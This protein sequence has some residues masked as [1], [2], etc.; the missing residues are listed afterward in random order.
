VRVLSDWLT[1][2]AYIV[3]WK[4]LRILP[5]RSAYR[6]FDFLAARAYKRNGKRVQRLRSNYEAV[7]AGKS[8]SEIETLVRNGLQSSMRYWCDTFRIGDWNVD[9]YSNTVSTEN[10]HL[11]FDGASSGRGVIIALPHA[12]NW[13][14][15]GLYFCSKGVKVHTVAEHLRPERLF[16][17]FLKHREAMGMKVLDLDKSVTDQLEGFLNQGFLVALVADR[18]LSRSGIDVNFF[19]RRARM[20]AGPALLALRT[21]ADLITAFVSFT[22]GGIHIKFKGPFSI[23]RGADPKIEVERVTQELANAFAEDI[24]TDPASW[25][26]QQRIFIDDADFIERGK[27]P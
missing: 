17:K 6:F 10:E 16:R 22:E 1:Y 21:K 13:D 23:N 3:L 14:H 12:G 8:K 15:A 20:P 7:A 27:N 11:L 25:H 2:F 5:E 19:S 24:S 9:R 4:F 18:D 26:M